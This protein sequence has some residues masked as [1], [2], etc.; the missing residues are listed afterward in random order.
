MKTV[1]KVIFGL[2]LA[3]FVIAVL[4]EASTLAA[5]A[6][7]SLFGG[8]MGVLG[9][10]IGVFFTLIGFALKLIFNPIVLILVIAFALS[11]RKRSRQD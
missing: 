8:V 1:L 7:F 2:M 4:I 11:R 10:V 6:V 9:A 5:G 3:A